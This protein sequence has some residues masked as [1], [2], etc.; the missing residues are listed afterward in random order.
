MPHFQS[1]KSPPT[2]TKQ[3]Q[4]S[5]RRH[6]ACPSRQ[7]ELSAFCTENSYIDSS[8]LLPANIVEPGRGEAIKR[9]R[10]VQPG[11]TSQA[12]AAAAAAA[13][14]SP[15]MRRWWWVTNWKWRSGNCKHGI[16]QVRE[17]AGFYVTHSA[18]NIGAIK[19]SQSWPA[20]LAILWSLVQC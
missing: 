16:R 11:S 15:R 7:L 13:S 6:R 20:K 4:L 1:E 14:P 10:L 9:R 19:C 3:L 8:R 12:A 17:W 2:Q 5:K 18:C